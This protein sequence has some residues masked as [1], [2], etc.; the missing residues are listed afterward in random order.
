MKSLLMADGVADC[1]VAAS[2]FL[3]DYQRL[4]VLVTGQK[5]GS[6]D[7]S[8]YLMQLNSNILYYER[9]DICVI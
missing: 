8:L 4:Q 6:K 3:N 7:T 1:E 9:D 5:H 2:L